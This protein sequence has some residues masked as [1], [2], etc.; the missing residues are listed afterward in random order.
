MWFLYLASVAFISGVVA[1]NVDTPTNMVQCQPILIT[2]GGGQSPYFLSALPG[3]QPAAAP[4]KSWDGTD[5]T[6]RTFTVDIPAGTTVT[7]AVRDSTGAQAFSDIVTVRQ[8]GTTDCSDSTGNSSADNNSSSSTSDNSSTASNSFT[9]SSVTATSSASGN[10]SGPT[11]SASDRPSRTQSAPGST[12]TNARSGADRSSVLIAGLV[13][14]MGM[15]G[16]IV[17][18]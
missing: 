5:S 18:G 8:G 17:L 3:G 4:L 9:T 15:V 13:G 2:Y 1:L 12:N 10:R 7:F 11:S 6:T 16:L 14:V